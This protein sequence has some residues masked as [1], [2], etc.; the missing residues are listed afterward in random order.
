MDTKVVPLDD[1]VSE[2]TRHGYRWKLISFSD[3]PEGAL[4]HGRFGCALWKAEMDEPLEWMSDE[5]IQIPCR[6]ARD[7]MEDTDGY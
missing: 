6:K 1:Y 5:N 4:M 7:W 3:L 2:F